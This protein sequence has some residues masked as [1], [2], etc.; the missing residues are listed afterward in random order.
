MPI[1]HKTEAAVAEEA[2]KQTN[3]RKTKKKGDYKIININPKNLFFFNSRLAHFLSNGEK[4]SIK[5]TKSKSEMH[6][7]A[8]KDKKGFLVVEI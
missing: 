1:W 7:A 3:I 8:H 5:F 4:R 2:D 6:L